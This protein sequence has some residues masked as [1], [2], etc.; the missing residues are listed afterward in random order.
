[1]LLVVMQHHFL[2]R[3]LHRPPR[4]IRRNRRVVALGARERTLAE[5]RRR[6]LDLL[7][8]CRG[9]N[10]GDSGPRPP[11]GSLIAG[12]ERDEGELG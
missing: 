9:D 7:A 11:I 8:G 10:T 12:A 1:M 5:R 2:V 6:H 4:A 3:H